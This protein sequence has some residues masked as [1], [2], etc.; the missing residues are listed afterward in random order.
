MRINSDFL[1]A[2]AFRKPVIRGT[3]LP[4]QIMKNTGHIYAFMKSLAL[5]VFLNLER[6]YLDC[7][8]IETPPELM[9]S[10]K[11]FPLA[12]LFMLLFPIV[13]FLTYRNGRRFIAD[14][15]SI[16]RYRFLTSFLFASVV[17][18]VVFFFFGH[19]LLLEWY[20]FEQ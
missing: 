4:E 18:S 13:C 12:L 17:F 16:H 1:K 10:R 20:G 8:I 19:S 14:F 5:M 7:Q 6:F 11:L 2:D 9:H 15:R 3:L